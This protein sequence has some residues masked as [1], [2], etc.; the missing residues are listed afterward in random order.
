MLSLLLPV[1]CGLSRAVAV[2][3]VV[4]GID[5]LLL[6]DDG[7]DV[8]DVDVALL[9]LV[10]VIVVSAAPSTAS[11]AKTNAKRCGATAQRH[12]ERT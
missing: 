4:D 10:L 3:V 8:D 2:A 1:L 7:D 5:V 6:V 12:S 11:Q 9:V